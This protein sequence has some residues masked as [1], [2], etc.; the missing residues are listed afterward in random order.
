MPDG[1]K[2]VSQT[3]GRYTVTTTETKN[4]EKVQTTKFFSKDGKQIQADYY[5]AAEI[6]DAANNSDYKDYY[7]TKVVQKD[8]K[9]FIAVTAKDEVKVGILANDFIGKVDDG[10]LSKY[11]PKYFEG[12]DPGYTDDGK[13]L[14]LS[15]KKNE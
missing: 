9:Y 1:I 7:Q 2:N 10:T 12:Y 5:T 14:S 8:G 11:N 3:T 4:G 6:S 13:P 15:N